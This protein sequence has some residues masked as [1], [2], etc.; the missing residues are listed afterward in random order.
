MSLM[1]WG[2]ACTFI[3]ISTS[4]LRLM[5]ATYSELMKNIYVC[6]KNLYPIMNN[7]TDSGFSTVGNGEVWLMYHGLF[8]NDCI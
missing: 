7:S 5:V 1:A 2:K 6:I 4:M 8:L 3:F